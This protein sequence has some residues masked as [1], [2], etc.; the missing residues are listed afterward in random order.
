MKE[1]IHWL[2]LRL[3][4]ETAAKAFNSEEII[5]LSPGWRRTALP[6]QPQKRS[7]TFEN[8]PVPSESANFTRTSYVHWSRVRDVS[9]MTSR[10][11][12]ASSKT[13]CAC[14]DARGR[15]CPAAERTDSMETSFITETSGLNWWLKTVIIIINEPLNV[16]TSMYHYIITLLLWLIFTN[17]FC[18]CW[19]Q[20]FTPSTSWTFRDTVSLRQTQLVETRLKQLRDGRR[21]RGCPSMLEAVSQTDEWVRG[22]RHRGLISVILREQHLVPLHSCS[23]LSNHLSLIITL[24]YEFHRKHVR[25]QE[26][27]LNNGR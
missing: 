21:G 9:V 20:W 24:V 18:F 23:P 11:L 4:C 7:Q 10:G 8:L 5:L 3:V 6:P 25:G 1:V 22:Q 27:K 16:F 15:C 26:H 13:W 19:S 17:S 14:P 2:S 12:C